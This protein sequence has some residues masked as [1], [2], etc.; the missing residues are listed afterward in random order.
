M[1]EIVDVELDRLR[2]NPHNS[3]VM[4]ERLLR[5][6]TG[7]IERS[8]RYPPIIV[9]PIAGEGGQ[10]YEILDGHH[11]VEALR[12]LKRPRARCIVWEADDDEALW[13]MATLNRL[14][15]QDDARKRAALLRELGGRVE[16]AALSRGLPDNDKRL[17]RLRE[18]TPTVGPPRP[19]QPLEAMPEAVHFFLL[20]GPRRQLE[21]RL[22]EVG[23]TREEALMK[24]AGA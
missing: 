9:R 1:N 3:N 24:L 12:R 10:A 15:G 22:R 20:P 18:M 16:A 21:A 6:L 11:R 4:G 13:L 19:P 23:G 14:Q 7:H 5:K 17:K 2:A 8:G